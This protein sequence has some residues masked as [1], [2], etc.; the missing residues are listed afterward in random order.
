MPID[1]AAFDPQLIAAGVPGL[2]V[3]ARCGGGGQKAVW[4]CSYLGASYVLKIL[5]ADPDSTERAK[6]ELEIYRRCN[7]SYLPK[8]GPLPLSA[9]AVGTDMVLFYL[10]E[11]ITGSTLERVAKPMLVANVVEMAKCIADAIEELWKNHFVHRDI[12]PANIMQK[13]NTSDSVLL[14][15]GLAL[16]AIGPSLTQT[17]GIV[18]T[19]GYLSPDQLQMNKRDLDFRSDLFG[20]GICMYVCS[21]NEHPFWNCDLPRGHVHHNTVTYPSPNPHRWN[22]LLRP[23]FCD[24]VMRLLEKERHLRYSRFDLLREDLNRIVT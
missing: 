13:L 12:K 24:F 19:V 21:T 20:L 8:L 15:A 1:L 10:E 3:G 16:D 17:G 6:R 2:Q 22:A 7:S 14:D 4:E 23:D 11:L 5:V 9:Q 18:G